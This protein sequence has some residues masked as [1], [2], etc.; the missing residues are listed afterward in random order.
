MAKAHAWNLLLFLCSVDI[1]S[2]F[3]SVVYSKL[4]LALLDQGVNPY[5]VAFVVLIL[6]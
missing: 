2:A 5:T 6:I 4:F 1:S 3:D